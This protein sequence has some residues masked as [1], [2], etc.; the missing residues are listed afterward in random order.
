MNA[1]GKI[2]RGIGLAIAVMMA[3]CGVILPPP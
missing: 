2:I 1:K 3:V